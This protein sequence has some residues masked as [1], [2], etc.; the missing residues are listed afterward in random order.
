MIA[1]P[2]KTGTRTGR[3]LA[4]VVR[5]AKELSALAD[6]LADE[7]DDAPDH[8]PVVESLGNDDTADLVA[9][10]KAIGYTCWNS[11]NLVE[12]VLPIPVR[13]AAGLVRDI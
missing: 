11:G 13:R 7:L 9:D 1:T 6:R 10:L 2:T 5:L 3:D 8:H 4:R 12:N